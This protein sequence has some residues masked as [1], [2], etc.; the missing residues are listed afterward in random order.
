MAGHVERLD[1]EAEILGHG[2]L[3][4]KVS[5][6]LLLDADHACPFVAL[7]VIPPLLHLSTDTHFHI[8]IG[9]N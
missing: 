5:D 9:E 7:P 8:H 6:R 4:E 2:T 3:S 1:E